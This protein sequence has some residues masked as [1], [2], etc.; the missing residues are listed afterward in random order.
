MLPEC[1][2][3]LVLGVSLGAHRKISAHAVVLE[4]SKMAGGA[5][6]AGVQQLGHLMAELECGR[7]KAQVPS[8]RNLQDKSKVNVHQMSDSI[9]ENIAIVS[10]FGLKQ[11]AGDCIPAHRRQPVNKV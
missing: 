8:R 10:V 4:E 5:V 11:V 6:T 3:S 9:H 7:L 2:S 1:A